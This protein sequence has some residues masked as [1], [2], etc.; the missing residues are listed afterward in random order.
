[1]ESLSDEQKLFSRW[2]LVLGVL[3]ISLA[4]FIFIETLKY[5]WETPIEIVYSNWSNTDGDTCSA[6]SPCYI[7]EE[8]YIVNDGV[9]IGLL[10]PF[11]SFI[12]GNHHLYAALFTEKYIDTVSDNGFANPYRAFDYLISSSLMIVVAAI[13][14]KAPPDLGFLFVVAGTQAA[15]ILVGFC[16]E[17]MHTKQGDHTD[18]PPYFWSVFIGIMIVYAF[19]WAALLMP[20]YFAVQDAP[21]VVIFFILYLLESFLRFPIQFVLSDIKKAWKRFR[22][23]SRSN[24]ETIKEKIIE[25]EFGWMALSAESKLPLLVLF[26]FGVVARSDSVLFGTPTDKVESGNTGPSDSNLRALFG[27]TVGASILLEIILRFDPGLTREWPLPDKGGNV[28]KEFLKMLLFSPIRLLDFLGIRPFVLLLAVVV[29]LWGLA[30]GLG[31]K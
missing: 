11:F 28:C 24:N 5:P 3:H 8:K 13:L 14:F 25:D 31:F 16:L 19:L 27:L 7:T 9:N 23:D 20:F 18:R 29:V 6:E 26:Y 10:I 2:N 22:K 21:P 1:M 30:F 15:T 4:I 12:S 17:L